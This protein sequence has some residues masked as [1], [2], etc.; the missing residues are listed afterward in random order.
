M[1]LVIYLIAIV[2]APLNPTIS[3]EYVASSPTPF[4]IRPQTKQQVNITIVEPV[5][6]IDLSNN[7]LYRDESNEVINNDETTTRRD[8]IVDFQ[9]SPRT[10]IFYQNQDS[11]VIRDARVSPVMV[12][13]GDSYIDAYRQSHA[14]AVA[15]KDDNVAEPTA[16]HP[17]YYE[18][19]YAPPKDMK[20]PATSRISL[21]HHQPT[22]IYHEPPSLGY[23]YNS[24]K[25]TYSY[26]YLHKEPEPAPPSP[27]YGSGF[28]ATSI[29]HHQVNY[30]PPPVHHQVTYLAPTQ[31][32]HHH[33]GDYDYDDH[34][35][36]HHES[37]G[38]PYQAP[39]FFDKLKM[40]FNWYILGKLL[41]K[42]I[43][44]KKFVK[45]AAILCLLFIIPKLKKGKNDDEEDRSR[46]FSVMSND[47]QEALMQM[48][49]GAMDMYAS[50]SN[51]MNEAPNNST[52]SSK[53]H[54]YDYY[55]NNS[56]HD[57]DNHHKDNSN[58]KTSRM[59][60]RLDEKYSF[61]RLWDMYQAN[62][63]ENVV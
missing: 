48:F 51:W 41:L 38:V 39:G 8:T 5:K 57:K 7:I 26:E 63:E 55:M 17:T 47:A 21:Y 4:T 2:L 12:S 49:V 1:N 44:F 31:Q 50:G 40:K 54:Y 13:S 46:M 58:C 23:H 33:H 6:S 25:P 61:A 56:K 18:P 15:A 52:S 42:L 53:D 32:V 35:H 24:P 19:Q 45:F 27:T 14:A 16:A 30:G 36:D 60:D 59:L 29:G 34:H 9:V 62:S 22:A 37:Y 43:L 10:K 11:N 28:V 20:P 3:G